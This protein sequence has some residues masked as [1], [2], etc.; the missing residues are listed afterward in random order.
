MPKLFMIGAFAIYFWSNESG[1]PVHVHVAP[2][3][4]SSHSVK[5]W[6][7]QDGQVV[8]ANN[9]L[10]LSQHEINFLSRYISLQTKYICEKWKE[11]FGELTFYC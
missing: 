7:T 1:E 11:Q 5:F 9:N 4:P 3:R 8:L 6:I 2:K 10:H